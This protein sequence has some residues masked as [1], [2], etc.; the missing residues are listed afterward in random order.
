MSIAIDGPA[1]AG[2]STIAQKLSEIYKL[3]YINTGAMYRA[4]TL[5][6]LK[7][8]ILPTDVKA[9]TELV[10]KLNMHFE[11][12][13]LLLDNVDIN[14]EITTP[15][16]GNNVSN[17]AAVPEVREILVQLQQ[18]M[19]GKYDVI[20]DGRDIGTV[21]LKNSK[22]KFFLTA[23]AEERARRRFNEFKEKGMEVKFDDILN[24]I[25]KR[26]YIDTHREYNPL[27]KAIDAIEIDTS[28][29]NIDQVV[30]SISEHIEK[31]RK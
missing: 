10:L 29:M 5:V 24:D 2:K 22:Y 3:M 1:G 16:I 14:D 26:D 27:R 7:N 25:V 9:L 12:D 20:M 21:V 6:A 13:R 4:V 31:L 17:Y 30:N 11:N 15:Y 8:N 19:A 23:T 18:V 28:F